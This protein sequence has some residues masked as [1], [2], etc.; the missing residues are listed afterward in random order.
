[1]NIKK[2]LHKKKNIKKLL[3][4]KLFSVFVKY[5]KKTSITGKKIKKRKPANKSL[6]SGWFLKVCSCKVELKSKYEN[7]DKIAIKAKK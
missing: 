3:I 2:L 1:M 7:L 6:Y 4:L 5:L